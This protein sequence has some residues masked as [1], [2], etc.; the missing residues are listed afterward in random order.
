MN[1]NLI[2][3]AESCAEKYAE[4]ILPTSHLT[5]EMMSKDVSIPTG[6]VLPDRFKYRLK[7][8]K[9]KLSIRYNG[10]EYRRNPFNMNRGLNGETTTWG[11]QIA[12]RIQRVYEMQTSENSQLRDKYLNQVK[13]LLPCA[14]NVEEWAYEVEK[15]RCFSLPSILESLQYGFIGR[16]GKGSAPQELAPL[17]PTTLSQG[18]PNKAKI[19]R[20]ESIRYQH[21]MHWSISKFPRKE[22]YGTE[23]GENGQ[24]LLDAEQTLA[25]RENFDFIFN[26]SNRELMMQERRYWIDVPNGAEIANIGNPQEAQKV[27]LILDDLL[28]WF[29]NENQRKNLSVA[30]LT[31][32]VNQS[33]TLRKEANTV[34]EKRETSIKGTRCTL[35]LSDNRIITIFCSTVD[36]I[37]CQEADDVMLSLRNVRRQGNIDS[38]NRANVA[39]TRARE[40]LFIIGKIENYKNARDPML[41]RLANGIK[42]ADHN[43]FWSE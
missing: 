40:A 30:L 42:V 27:S 32:Y 19:S 28:H 41:K 4:Q 38:P 26:E 31:P 15:I 39:L 3:I 25:A 17:F 9:E 10:E 16:K 7:L 6:N 1:C 23:E 34:L 43:T 29:E 22:F 21:R 5:P 13:S 36:K 18:F 33:R 24:R 20:F 8:E 14:T 35:R 11:R 2:V 37:Q 12:W